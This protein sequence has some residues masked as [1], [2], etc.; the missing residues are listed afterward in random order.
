MF[1]ARI[2]FTTHCSEREAEKIVLEQK[3]R[4]LGNMRLVGFGVVIA[5]CFAVIGE[6]GL[7]GWWVMVPLG[8]IFWL[9]VSITRA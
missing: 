7:S 8:I 9:G 4:V 5:I 3:H 6:W 2:A 1:D